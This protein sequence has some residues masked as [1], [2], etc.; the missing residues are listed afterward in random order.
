MRPLISPLLFSVKNMSAF[1]A[2]FLSLSVKSLT[3]RG[4]KQFLRWS[5]SHLFWGSRVTFLSEF[6]W[7]R[8]GVY[9]VAQNLRHAALMVSFISTMVL[10]MSIA[11]SVL[12]STSSFGLG[13]VWVTKLWSLSNSSM[14]SNRTT[15]CTYDCP[16]I[17][18]SSR[19]TVLS[20]IERW[21]EKYSVALDADVTRVYGNRLWSV[22]TLLREV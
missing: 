7:D 22:V 19:S 5:W 21:F 2:L 4:E 6:S 12:Y 1:I 10:A 8:E 9:T 3:D 11:S 15:F 18:G 17:V 16:L 14:S 20:G 13:L